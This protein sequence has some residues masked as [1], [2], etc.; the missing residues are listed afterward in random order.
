MEQ[1]KEVIDNPF[2][3]I[4]SMGYVRKTNKNGEKI[5]ISTAPGP[6]YMMFSTW[7]GNE[8]K[9]LYVHREMMRA[10]KPTDDPKLTHVCFKDHD[11][12]NL[13]LDNLY[14]TTQTKRMRR[15]Y[16]EGGYAKGEAHHCAKLTDA[17]VI[18]MR[19]M[20]ETEEYTQQF[21]ADRFGIHPSTLNN[22]IKKRYW[23]HI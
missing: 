13:N 2:Y 20:W 5:K 9:K 11:I 7:S 21:I 18:K 17:D 16:R 1:W 8:I 3:E 19:E 4:S 12:Y 23:S 10:F 14:W 6:V 15:R 22:I